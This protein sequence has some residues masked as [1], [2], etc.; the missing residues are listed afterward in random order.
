MDLSNPKAIAERG[1][2]IYRDKY[3]SGYELEHPGQFVAIDITTEKPYIASSAKEAL[4]LAG[5]DS[6]KGIFHLVRV[7]SA[8][9][10]RVSYTSN[11]AVDW[12][13]R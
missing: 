4:E 3:Q 1:E 7:G 12:I 5:A 9:A 11:A 13:F 6:P 2:Q 8:G 10:F